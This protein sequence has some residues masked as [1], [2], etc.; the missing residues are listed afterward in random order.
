MR[1]ARWGLVLLAAAVLLAG[2]G[3]GD[4]DATTE[5]APTKPKG[6]LR[7]LGITLNGYSGAENLGILMADWEDYFREVG[8]KV[9]VYSP[10]SPDRPV[11]YTAD[12]SVDLGVSHA[13][14]VVLAQSKGAPIVA[15]GSLVAQPTAAMIWLKKSGI[16]GIADLKEKTVAT[17][18]LSFQQ[19]FLASV[20]ADAGLSLAD[21]KVE[22][23]GYDL[24]TSLT[25]GRADAIFGGTWNVAGAQLEA[26]GQDPVITRVEDLGIPPYDELVAIVRRDRLAKDPQLFRDFWT[27]VARGTTAA[28]AD[29]NLAFE[30]ADEDVEA[31]YRVSSMA[32]KAQVEATLPL[33]SESGEMDAEQAGALVEWMLEEKMI[34]RS[35]PVSKLFLD[36]YLPQPGS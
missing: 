27:A 16:Q 2:C 11:E 25:K 28:T 24:V 33:L 8:L 5:A 26:L 32:R 19:D 35:L 31:D 3:G 22:N 36:E 7:E 6:P 21:V 13:P 14:E 12:G 23:A 15:I 30:A 10:N 20:L 34:K 1:I 18:G 29:P 4:D 17:E 9:T